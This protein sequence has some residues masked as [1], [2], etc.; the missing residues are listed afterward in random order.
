MADH[1]LPH[2]Y[3]VALLSIAPHLAIRTALRY[4]TH[5]HVASAASRAAVAPQA[6]IQ[7][8]PVPTPTPSDNPAADLE[9]QLKSLTGLLR[10]AHLRQRFSTDAATS[11]TTSAVTTPP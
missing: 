9:K 3:F 4:Q 2:S 5:F 6:T 10:L 11:N 1:P 8:T 7:P